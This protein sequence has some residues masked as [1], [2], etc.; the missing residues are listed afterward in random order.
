[1]LE[2]LNGLFLTHTV[3]TTVDLLSAHGLDP[4]RHCHW[5]IYDLTARINRKS[6]VRYQEFACTL[7]CR[8]EVA[9]VW[10]SPGSWIAF[11]V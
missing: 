2:N 5:T 1:M 6:Q 10:N 8:T 11:A 9:W 4:V 3:Y 7:S